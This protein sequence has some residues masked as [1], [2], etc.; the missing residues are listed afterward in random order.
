[1]RAFLLACLV[2]ATS[3]C[4]YALA[5]RGNTLPSSIKIIGV[6][7]FTNRSIVPNVDLVVTDAVRQEF[8]GKGKYQ[9][10]PD[11]NAVDAVLVGTITSVTL[12]PA[13]FGQGNTPSAYAID[14]VANV[15][16]KHVTDDNKVLWSNP[17]FRISDDYQVTAGATV[18]NTA[19]ASLSTQSL[20]RIA[21]KFSR[22]IVTSIFE[23]F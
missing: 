13:A 17:S 4:G 5:G 1:M 6:P 22:E 20:E 15:E 9:I 16:F 23:A 8:Q 14:V 3:S 18:D 11:E 19:L 2:L 12:R 7:Q 21:K 10:R